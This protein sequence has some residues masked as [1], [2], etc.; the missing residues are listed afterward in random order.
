MR[1]CN[2]K[3]ER[4]KR[5]YL[6][7]QKEANR[8]SDSTIDNIRKALIRL[9]TFTDNQDFRQFAK[10]TAIDFKQHLLK[11]KAQRSGKSL[12][13][14]TVNTTLRHV[15]DFFRWLCVKPGFKQMNT[16]NIDYLNLSQKEVTAATSV[17]AKRAPTIEQ[18]MAVLNA[19]PNKTEVDL[20]NRAVFAFVALT[21]VRDGALVTL[22]MKHIRLGDQLVE[23]IGSEVATKFG[24]TI[25]TYFFPVGEEIQRIVCDWVM[26]LRRD[27]LFGDDDPLFPRTKVSLDDD[28]SFCNGGLDRQPWQSAGPVTRIFRDAFENAGL[29]YYS[30]HT[31]RTT[32]TRLGE[33]VCQ[34]PAE[35]KAWSQNLGHEGVLTTFTSYG[36]IDE[37]TQGRIIRQL[38]PNKS[39]DQNRLSNIDRKLDMLL[40][41][42]E[43]NNRGDNR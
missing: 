22:R 38:K 16:R 34:S 10:Q 7:W 24:K 20:R 42:R 26:F 13:K 4:L 29:E 28:N 39:G 27:K 1:K 21:G 2:A 5:E 35:F 31:L 3:N 37:F 12:C 23:Q 8:K 30:P 11:S 18:V 17:G 33:E 36:Q 6:E 15:Q 19:M 32:L 40:K 9:E 25:C 14:S 41:D 43:Q